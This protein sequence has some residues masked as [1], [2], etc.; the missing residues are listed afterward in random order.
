MPLRRKSYRRFKDLVSVE[1]IKSTATP[2]ADGHIDKSD[3]SN[4]E[5]ITTAYANIIP[6]TSREFW[7]FRGLR[8]DMTHAIEVR[9]LENIKNLTTENR[10]KFGSRYF[11]VTGVFDMN[12]E[13][14]VL[15]ITAKE[16][17]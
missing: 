9:Y 2:A 7:Q 10:L 15:V 4:W 16:A 13:H 11:N 6:Q 1:Q 3:P 8:T 5:E 12:E 14:R 17:T